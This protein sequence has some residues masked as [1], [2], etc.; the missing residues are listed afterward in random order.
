[1]FEITNNLIENL[2]LSS[3]IAHYID[4]KE[5]KNK[6]II[7][8]SLINCMISTVLTYY[9]II[10]VFQT[11]MIQIVLWFFLYKYVDHFSIKDITISLFGN[12]ML[13][14]ASYFAILF[15]SITTHLIPYQIFIDNR[16][17]VAT[18]ILHHVL[19][20]LFIIIALKIRPISFIKIEIKE[21]NY[22]FIF[23]NIL[24]LVLVYY[25]LTF[26]LSENYT[27][28]FTLIYLCI[29]FLFFTFCYFFNRF[30]H[31]ITELY[32][33]KLNERNQKYREANLKNLESIKEYIDNANHRINYILRSIE[34]DLNHQ[35]YEKA[36]DKIK[37]S[38]DVI[39]K[40]SP[41]LYTG[42]DLFDYMLNLEFK[43]FAQQDK[44]IKSCIF[45]TSNPLYDN[46]QYINKLI[47]VL[48]LMLKDFSEIELYLNE[49]PIQDKTYLKVRLI[50]V[51]ADQL[52][53]DKRKTLIKDLKDAGCK[54]HLNDSLLIVT[55][56][57]ELSYETLQTDF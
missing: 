32:E 55:Y 42:N 21:M 51:E 5:S 7:L 1:M 13:L 39:N 36:K 27:F 16:L 4:L 10:G 35:D 20:L 56:T 29:I 19:Y 46:L 15:L 28:S 54:T 41:V 34:Y 24:V 43:Y 57:D 44:S 38:N 49:T 12:I 25:F 33:M 18:V 31:L 3:F 30:I 26:I 11:A 37:I 22:L 2:L 48:K 47:N 6:F 40:V 9:N 17:Y 45:I 23:E 14:M 50:S 53:E 52:T 8:T